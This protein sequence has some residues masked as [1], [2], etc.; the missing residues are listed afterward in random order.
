MI[1]SKKLRGK[2]KSLDCFF[3]VICDEAIDISFYNFLSFYLTS[4][5]FD[6]TQLFQL[7][8]TFSKIIKYFTDLSK[9][10]CRKF[11]IKMVTSLRVFNFEFVHLSHLD[12]KRRWEWHRTR[13]K[14]HSPWIKFV[15]RGVVKGQHP[16]LSIR[17]RR[18][19]QFIWFLREH[20]HFRAWQSIF[21]FF[22]KELSITFS[23]SSTVNFM[24]GDSLM[25]FY[26]KKFLQKE[27]NDQK[28][29][30]KNDS[31]KLNAIFFSFMHT[32]V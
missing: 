18:I 2:K 26:T 7:N 1:C 10:I 27:K 22:S 19:D 13:I 14:F 8:R 31:F 24:M 21:F 20:S 30:T 12:G 29:N 15:S 25:L 5:I 9:V 6:G 4:A 3:V 23:Y 32:Y 11:H 28:P 17:G 16:Q